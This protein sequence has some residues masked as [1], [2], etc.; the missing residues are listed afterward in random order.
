MDIFKTRPQKIFIAGFS[1][2]LLF[3]NFYPSSGYSQSV[4][5]IHSNDTHGVY[6]PLKIKVEDALRLVGGMRAASHYL[7]MLRKNEKN[8]ILIDAGDVMTGTWAAQMEYKGAVG[9]VMVEFLNLLNYDIWAPGNHL[10]D[11]GQSNVRKLL[12]LAKPE[13]INANIIYQDSGELFFNKPYFIIERAGLRIGLIA[14]MEEN[15]LLE[16]QREAT[17]NLNVL[18]IMPTLRKYIP[19]LDQTTDVIVVLVHSRFE[20][21]VEVALNIPDIDVVLV[22][23]EDGRFE[24][25]NGVL[26]KST[27]GHQRTLGYMKLEIKEDRVMS[28]DQDLIWLWADQDIIPSPEITDMVAKVDESIKKDFLKNIGHAKLDLTRQGNPVESP[29]GNLITDAMCWK[30]GARIGFQNSRGIRADLLAGP[31][32]TADVYHVT[33]FRNILIE[34]DLTGQQIKDALEY[35]IEEGYDRLQVS[36]LTYEYYSKDL[37]PFGSRI[38]NIIVGN[39]VLVEEGKVLYPEKEYTAVS[40]EYVVD[41]AKD[42]YFGFII[43]RQKNSKELLA[44]TLSDY[45]KKIRVLENGY[46]NRIREINS[47]NIQE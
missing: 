17:K 8:L 38:K 27:Y 18:P 34:F 44:K 37:K 46:E 1:F 45:I 42:K 12:N 29:M 10:F 20:T 23:S 3:F 22:A 26:V 13:V 33:P 15:F 9:G 16:V 43:K 19:V 28:Y 40:N 35:D 41:H 21:G 32:T 2:F 25:I 31:I 47:S 24:Q 7:N 5:L 36:G 30:T 6:K 4:T 11:Q 14:V 39:E